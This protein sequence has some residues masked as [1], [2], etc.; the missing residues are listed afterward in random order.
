[1]KRLRISLLFSLSIVI[2]LFGS[3]SNSK[4]CSRFAPFKFSE[5][6]NADIIVRATAVK[7]IIPPIPN[8]RTTGI[9]ESTIEFKVEET[10]WGIDIP[11]V[12]RLHGY[13]AD[14]DDFNEMPLPYKFIRKN[15]RSGSCF[16]NSYKAGAKFL[17][18]LR[19]NSPNHITTTDYSA[20]ISP[21]GP[22]NEQLRN[23]DD[24][25]VKWVKAYISPC[26]NQS[27]REANYAETPKAKMDALSKEQATDLDKY[28][29]AKCY[30]AKYGTSPIEAKKYIQVINNF[31][32]YQ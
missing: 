7:Y 30:I 11:A 3:V 12:I 26:I 18:F 29:L 5:L 22:N 25:W 1:M 9:P 14:T 23:Q 17:L 15:G 19:K 4:A 27:S 13:L 21:L 20:E 2:I 16:A 28:R 31:E 8:T 6:F 32:A 24:P 10:I